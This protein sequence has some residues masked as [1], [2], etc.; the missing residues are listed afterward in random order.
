MMRFSPPR[1][2]G[3]GGGQNIARDPAIVDTS[4][5]RWRSSLWDVGR[6]SWLHRFT[7]IPP[8][9]VLC[10]HHVVDRV[11]AVTGASGGIGS[12]L[13]QE[14]VSRGDRVIAIARR[15]ET[16]EQM[17]FDPDAVNAVAMDLSSGEG[18]PDELSEL[19]NLD[20]L[21]HCAGVSHVAAVAE[22]PPDLWQ[23]TLMVNLIAP[24]ELTRL[25]LP[26]LRN[27]RGHVVFINAAYGVHAVPKWSAYAASRTALRE[28][29]DSLRLE[30]QSNG[31]KVASVYPDGTATERLRR[32]RESFGVPYDPEQCLTPDFVAGA[33]ADL[34]DVDDASQL[35]EVIVRR[36]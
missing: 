35:S 13:V 24:A 2:P 30:E 26:A 19:R 15:R 20:G 5:R 3:P 23:E 7:R 34:L 9:V 32:T 18:I 4:T 36:K 14:L 28:L 31:V 33:I 8:R 17:G 11:I 22:S 29:A 10:E 12:A 6:L 21:I 16:I 25:L 27:A 1:R